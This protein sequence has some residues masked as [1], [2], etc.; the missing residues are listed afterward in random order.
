MNSMALTTVMPNQRL[1]VP[2]T[3]DSNFSDVTAGTLRSVIGFILSKMT[4]NWMKFSSR[5]CSCPSLR[6]T[7]SALSVLDA[8]QMSPYST[9]FSLLM[10]SYPFPEMY[11]AKTSSCLVTWGHG[12]V[13]TTTSYWFSSH[14][15]RHCLSQLS[16]S[17]SAFS[18]HANCL[19]P[20]TLVRSEST[21]AF[22]L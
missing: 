21:P 8:F 18:M 6:T 5:R 9:N 15:S 4:F 11:V 14:E 20:S 3:S 17:T 7:S 10:L 22:R 12:A 1:S 2:P 19:N 13:E 16:R